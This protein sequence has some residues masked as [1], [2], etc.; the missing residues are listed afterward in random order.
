MNC[1]EISKISNFVPDKIKDVRTA[2]N[3]LNSVYK[4]RNQE[5]IP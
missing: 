3:K 1:D 2:E 5:R 4:T